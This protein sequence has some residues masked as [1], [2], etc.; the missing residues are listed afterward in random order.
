VEETWGYGCIQAVGGE[1]SKGSRE[2]LMVDGNGGE[3]V[4]GLNGMG[5]RWI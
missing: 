3:N 2:F 5:G 1:E 4:R